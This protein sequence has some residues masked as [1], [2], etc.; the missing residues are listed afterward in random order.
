MADCT[1]VV[2]TVNAK[3]CALQPNASKR[4]QARVAGARARETMLR[5][6]IPM[7]TPSLNVLQ[8]MHRQAIKRMR[9][10]YTTIFRAR[11][12]AVT[13]VKPGQ[14][15]KVWIER[16][17]KRLLDHDNLVGGCKPLVDALERAG[18]IWRDSPRFVRV[19]Y[20]QIKASA[21]RACTLVVVI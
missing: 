1:G 17:G 8:R 15:R 5:I 9:D 11:S 2:D 14:F 4:A 16:R 19:E 10:Q 12:T 18:L 20:S 7:P 13:R 21:K 3:R 6:E